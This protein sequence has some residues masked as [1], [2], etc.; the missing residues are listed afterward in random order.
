MFPNASDV[1]HLLTKHSCDTH[2]TMTPQ[3]WTFAC[4]M[5]VALTA[6]TTSPHRTD[7]KISGEA[8]SGTTF[9]EV[10]MNAFI[11]VTCSAMFRQ[12]DK[13]DRE[14]TCTW[15]DGRSS[16]KLHANKGKHDLFHKH[17]STRGPLSG[18]VKKALEPC[19][20]M[21]YTDLWT[22]CVRAAAAKHAKTAQHSVL[23]LRE[24]TAVCQSRFFYHNLHTNARNVSRDLDEYVSTQCNNTFTNI[25]A[26]YM[27]ASRY[28]ELWV[29][30]H[31]GF[32]WDN[33]SAAL[34]EW[35][36]LP[37]ELVVTH[38]QLSETVASRKSMSAVEKTGSLPGGSHKGGYKVRDHHR[39]T[40]STTARRRAICNNLHKVPPE[41]AARWYGNQTWIDIELH[42][43]GGSAS[44][45]ACK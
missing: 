36:D 35:L 6:S 27:Y 26:R 12:L 15:D 19:K 28:P 8:K 9:L 34:G 18:K 13:K 38:A 32:V 41:I 30:W 7:V 11:S 2:R 29:I 1:C 17:A 45:F 22:R 3:W 33:I 39:A 25:I 14:I 20:D 21:G 40:M 43:G 31:Y 16:L 44:Y 5:A 37:H 23:A 4:C 24:P 10:F 42:V